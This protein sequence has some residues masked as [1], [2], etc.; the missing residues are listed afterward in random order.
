VL[1]SGVITLFE[2]PVGSKVNASTNQVVFIDMPLSAPNGGWGSLTLN[3]TTEGA[4]APAV[5]P[6]PLPTDEA[7][8]S[9]PITTPLMS[10][11]TY[12]VAVTFTNGCG[13]P[14]AIG[15]GTFSAQ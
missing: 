7:F 5:I 6:S 12:A 13:S 4:L 15:L 10:G 2:P 3:G 11:M 9:A 1:P 8:L 14:D